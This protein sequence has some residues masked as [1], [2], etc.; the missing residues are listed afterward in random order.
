MISTF[1]PKPIPI[2]QYYGQ[3]GWETLS[4]LAYQIFLAPAN[5]NLQQTG[6]KYFENAILNTKNSSWNAL[7]RKTQVTHFGKMQV[8]PLEKRKL[9]CSATQIWHNQRR[10]AQ[11]NHAEGPSICPTCQKL[12]DNYHMLSGWSH[13]NINRTIINR[14][15]AA[16]RMI[17]KAIQKGETRVH[18]C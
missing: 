10:A 16:G 7:S 8:P 9:P 17:L 18:A 14:H 3:Q 1:T 6:S 11:C 2:H 5:Q 12:D 13:P 4:Q 15:N